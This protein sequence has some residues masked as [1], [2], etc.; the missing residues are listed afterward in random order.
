MSSNRLTRSRTNRV[1]GGVCAGLGTYLNID[2]P[3]VRLFFVLLA[4][5]GSLGFWIYVLLWIIVPNEDDSDQRMGFDNFESRAKGM[6]EDIRHAA[7]QP[8]MNAARI[9]GIGLL[10]VGGYMLLRNLNIPALAFL[11][12]DFLFPLLLIVA[13][14]VLLVR[15]FRKDS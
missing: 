9:V 14:V 8:D 10:L 6:G 4:V 13:G 7:R 15:V 1:L 12:R 2:P 3:W 5:T 11:N